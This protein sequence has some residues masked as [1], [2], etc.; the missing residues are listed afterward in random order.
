VG[1]ALNAVPRLGPTCYALADPPR[2]HSASQT[3]V[4][5]L[6]YLRLSMIFV[7]KP[8]STFPDHTLRREEADS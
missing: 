2:R 4:N 7:G 1:E 5:A 8:V 3:R 6:E